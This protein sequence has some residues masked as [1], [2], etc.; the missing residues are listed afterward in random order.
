MACR[1]RSVG[2]DSCLRHMPDLTSPV[3]GAEALAAMCR[4]QGPLGDVTTELQACDAMLRARDG[5]RKYRE[6]PWPHVEA[7]LKLEKKQQKGAAYVLGAKQES[8]GIFYVAY[9]ANVNSHREYM[10][11]T[12]N[13]VYF[14][15]EVRA[16]SEAAYLAWK[17]YMGLPQARGDPDALLRSGC[18]SG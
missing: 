16:C 2:L 8:P 14:R 13:G 17:G 9:V 6:G 12:P 1:A 3:V 11:V 15:H 10:T 5:C 7:Q 4:G 18:R